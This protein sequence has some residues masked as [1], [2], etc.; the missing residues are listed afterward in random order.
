MSAD[1]RNP[2]PSEEHLKVTDYFFYRTFDVGK[3][4]ISEDLSSVVKHFGVQAIF[5]KQ[6]SL[7]FNSI[8]DPSLDQITSGCNGVHTSH[9]SNGPPALETQKA[10]VVPETP[11]EDHNDT[12]NSDMGS[13]KETLAVEENGTRVN[14]RL[15]ELPIDGNE[16]P[17][18]E[19]VKG[20]NKSLKSP[21]LGADID[22]KQDIGAVCRME[23]LKDV[24]KK[25]DYEKE[26]IFPE[27][28]HVKK[29]EF[30]DGSSKAS[31]EQNRPM[32]EAI[33]AK[34]RKSPGHVVHGVM[35]RPEIVRENATVEG[36]V[37]D[38]KETPK[39]ESGKEEKKSLK[40][41][42]LRV[43]SEEDQ[44]VVTGFRMEGLEDVVKKTENCKK[45]LLNSENIPVKKA[46]LND[47]SS[48]TSEGVTNVVSEAKSAK[49]ERI[50]ARKLIQVTK[51]PEVESNKWFKELP[52]NERLQKGYDQGSVILIENFD[53][54]YTSTE[55]EDI[56]WKVFAERCAAKVIPQT[57]ISNPKMGQ[58]L[59][60]FKTKDGAEL[61]VKK[62]DEG[63]LMLSHERPLIARKAYPVQSGKSTKFAGH[64]FVEKH[65]L[66]MQKTFQAEDM[67]KALATS[68]CSQP[69]TIE[70]VMAMDWRLLQEKSNRW[71]S[72]LYK[73]QEGEIMKVKRK[74]KV[75]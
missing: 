24:V 4:T 59:V 71:W 14:I 30:S 67:K 49:K 6:D 55:V 19:S 63:C 47:Y 70:Y 17:K 20:K 27:N 38:E 10:V 51:R 35:K 41:P 57:A 60:I 3:Y 53:P 36:L 69:N 21:K 65:K 33:A 44:D 56:I 52:W 72:E 22:N 50:P 5:N 23:V 9:I 43:G 68:H 25:E 54:L 40:R 64:I 31:E 18:E 7:C 16:T 8:A 39:E 12:E 61:A 75:F 13:K 28:L 73:Q 11:K 34:K 46:R 48:R 42:K 32:S 62:L 74:Q 1:Q 66:Q 58:A 2:K 45:E 26:D 29:D 15:E 37:I